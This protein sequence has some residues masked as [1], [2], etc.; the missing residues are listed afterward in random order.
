[1]KQVTRLF[2]TTMSRII[3]KMYCILFIWDTSKNYPVIII[4]II[5]NIFWL[6]D[7]RRSK[8]AILYSQEVFIS[9]SGMMA[10]H[11]ERVTCT[12]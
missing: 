1:M 11:S 6:M 9:L 5:I 7:A 8:F 12:K 3:N 2:R 4:I 10:I